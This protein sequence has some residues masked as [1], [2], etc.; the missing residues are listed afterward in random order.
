[1]SVIISIVS[2]NLKKYL[3]DKASVFFFVGY[4]GACAISFIPW[5]YAN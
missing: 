3:R 4:Y 5:R 2:R 1:M